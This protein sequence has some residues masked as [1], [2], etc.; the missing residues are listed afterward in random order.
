MG[1]LEAFRSAGRTLYSL[2]LVRGAEGNLSAF[3]GSVIVITRTGASLESL[4]DEDLLQGELEDPLAGASSDLEVH[5]RMYREHGPGAVA[6]AHPAGS[7]PE[8]GRGGPGK[9]GVYAY[10]PTLED[11]AEWVVRASRA[12]QQ[13]GGITS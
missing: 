5:R 2:G 12:G 11:A 4:A 7:V 1:E 3:D 9:H 8:D 13:E 10:G 6:H